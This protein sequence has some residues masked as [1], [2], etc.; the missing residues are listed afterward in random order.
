MPTMP[1]TSGID[2]TD[3]ASGK[4]IDGLV[5]AMPPRHQRTR[6]WWQA[7]RCA[8]QL[9]CM[10]PLERKAENG[11]W[12]AES[13]TPDPEP[14]RVGT[15]WHEGVRHLFSPAKRISIDERANGRKKVPD[16][17]L[18]IPAPLYFLNPES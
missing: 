12:K 14:G 6:H 4:P 11:E 8:N 2:G 16:H 18:L 3:A 5:R 9:R 10:P 13:G 7:S 15:T 1:R 17:A